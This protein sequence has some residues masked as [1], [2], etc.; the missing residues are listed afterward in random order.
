MQYMPVTILP[1]L[2]SVPYYHLETVNS[3]EAVQLCVFF[4]CVFWLKGLKSS[5][6]KHLTKRRRAKRGPGLL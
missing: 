3:I 5:Q 2:N 1:F 6:L 4:I